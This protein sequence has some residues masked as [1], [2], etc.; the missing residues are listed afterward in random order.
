MHRRRFD[1]AVQQLKSRDSDELWLS[2]GSCNLHDARMGVLT[3]ALAHNSTVTAL[4]LSRNNITSEGAQARAW[5]SR[6]PCTQRR[7]T[8]QVPEASSMQRA[9]LSWRPAPHTR[10]G[11]APGFYVSY[12]PVRGSTLTYRSTAVKVP[13]RS[14][15]PASCKTCEACGL[16]K[17]GAAGGAGVGRGE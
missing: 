12:L 3:E 5:Q 7:G 2:L 10:H 6:S 4:D 16:A 11:M 1:A 9:S 8:C 15:P 17:A 13:G 14:H